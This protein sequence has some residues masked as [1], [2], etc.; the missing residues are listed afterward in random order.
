MIR[1]GVVA[2]GPAV[3]IAD[4]TRNDHTVHAREPGRTLAA[5]VTVGASHVAVYNWWTFLLSQR[6]CAQTCGWLVRNGAES[7]HTQWKCWGLRCMAIA[8]TGP[9]PGKARVASCACRESQ[10]YPHATLQQAINEP[11]V[12][13]KFIPL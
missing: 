12:Y 4:G 13:R 5:L 8:M 7:V 11:N 3:G 10:N 2:A 6:L 9:L 1:L